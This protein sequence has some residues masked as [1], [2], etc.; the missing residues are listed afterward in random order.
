MD[1]ALETIFIS[2]L[3]SSASSSS[4]QYCSWCRYYTPSAHSM[5]VIS[6]F[7]FHEIRW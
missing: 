1:D 7:F 6:R 2:P 4:A 3:V 5:A